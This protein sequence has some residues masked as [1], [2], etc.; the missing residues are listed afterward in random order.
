MR[1]RA[2]D[3]IRSTSRWDL[4]VIGGGATGLGAAVDAAARGHRTLLLEARDFAQGTSSRST[5]L[6]HGGVRYLARGEVGLVREALRERVLLH[7]NAPRLVHARSFLVPCRGRLEGWKY[8]LGLKLYDALAGRESLGPSRWVGLDEALRL[9]PT[10]EARGLC[11][12]VVYQDGQFDDARLAIA[13]LKTLHHLGGTALNHAAVEGLWKGSG[14]VEGAILRDMEGGEERVV[15]ARAFIN[16]TGVRV[17]AVR[18]LDDPNA[19]PMVRPSQGAHI[20]LDRSFLPGETAI[21]VPKTRDGRVLFLIPWLDRVLVGTTDTPVSAIEDEPRP[22][23]AEVAFLLEHAAE[24]LARDPST[25]DVRS[26]FAGLRP[27]VDAGSDRSTARLSREH[28]VSV[29]ASGLVTITGGKWTTYRVMAADAVD[30]AEE[31]AGLKKVPCRTAHLRLL[32]DEESAPA[33]ASEEESIHPALPY[34][35][36]DLVRAVRFEMARNVEDVL[37]RRTRCLFLDA[38]ASLEAAPLVAD[39]LANALGRDA[40]WSREQ[41]AWFQVLASRYLPDE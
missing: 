2:L 25:A 20:V 24:Y 17:D 7:R 34:R 38:R 41:V 4:V 21:L 15:K 3:A 32:D 28:V 8:R 9:T 40:V 19:A 16:A 36:S 18:Q 5:K 33:L 11:G 22:L 39:V 1:D 29:S 26:Q 37:A 10:L 14:R 30:R 13:L 12:G 6:I 35:R 23:R 31:V 27:L